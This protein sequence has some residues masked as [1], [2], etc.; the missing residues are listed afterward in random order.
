ML[1][2][3]PVFIIGVFRSGTSLLCSL[4]NQNPG[5]ALMYEFDIWNFPRPL[6]N[7]RFRRN[8]AERIEFY[9]QALSRH[10]MIAQDQAA[11]L[12]RIR[13]PLDL[14]RAF[15]ERK[16][17][18]VSGEKSPFYC[19]RLEQLYKR[20]P[21]AHFI[22]VWRPPGEIYRSVVKAGQ[23]SRFFGKPGMLSRMIYQQEQL[24]RQTERIE[25]QG[26]RIFRVDYA[27][28]VD[29]TEKTCRDISG[30]LEVPFDQ[31][32]LELNKADLSAIYKAPHHA[33]LRR[34][35]IE[36]QHYNEELVP[37][38][39]VKKLERYRQ[40]WEQMQ[41]GWLKPSVKSAQVTPGL[42]E[43]AYHTVVGKL[44]T[45]YDSLVRAGFEFL[46]LQ[47]LRLYR[48][49]KIWI[50]NPPSG[51]ADERTSLLRDLRH[52]WQTLLLGGLLLAVVSEAQM[53]SNP[54]LLFLLFYAFPCSLVALLVNS[55]WA[56]LFVLV[57]SF[58]G[59]TIQFESDADYRSALVFVWN[60]IVRFIL[61][62]VFILTLARIRQEC[63]QIE[64]R[65]HIAAGLQPVA[66]AKTALKFSIITPSFR[67]SA[68][69]K[70]CIASVADQKGIE[71]E[72][73]VQDSC[74]DDGT[75]D[76]LPHDTRVK[77]FIEKDAGMY[78]AVNRGYRRATGDI[79]AYLNCDEQYLPGALASV[80]QF[81]LANPEV[82][83]LFAG[84]IV[85]DGDGKYVCHRHGMVPDL[86]HIWYRFP[87]LTSSIF[88][89]RSVIQKRGIFFD[90]KWRDLGDFHWV[91]E[92]MKQRVPMTERSIFTS[93]F[94]DTGENM[95]LKPNAVREKKETDA[96]IPT[97]VRLLK[98]LWIMNH[99]LRRLVH[100]HF[101]LAK[102]SYAIY[103][104][105][106]PDRRVTIEVP[107]PTPI[108]WSRL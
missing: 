75:G 47:W 66:A 59:P 104:K 4:L 54:H 77:A 29:R 61:L 108:W 9:N 100:G 72:H 70:L 71:L 3:N 107:H 10:G 65:E 92:L 18:V 28:I 6:L 79:L 35:I 13:T 15:G 7:V 68:W 87:A 26:A 67:N 41:A 89:R 2:Q 20:Y 45:Y 69:L 22:I 94:A 98:P 48:V 17:A 64:R 76:W 52:H 93:V 8:W 82:E 44:W 73:I 91:F 102:T 46:P 43:F 90:T 1:N 21:N 49:L 31:R 27:S 37:P 81:F 19:D 86:N 103:T 99:R 106:S 30:F 80:E 25:K 95:N 11:A 96:M 12:D 58:M 34:G 36:R 63:H 105:A 56:T 40:R 38:A 101:S 97:N 5:I 42:L 51:V 62:E 84:S 85:T 50:I 60:F 23:T 78:D 88:I 33:Y 74:S 53:R 16:G 14:Y 55:R 57:S 32:M 83:V 39:I 24:I